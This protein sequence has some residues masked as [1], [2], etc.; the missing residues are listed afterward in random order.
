MRN[1]FEQ[2]LEKL[3]TELAVMG[4]LCEK[5]IALATRILLDNETD[6]KHE[7]TAAEEAIDKKERAIEKHC[8]RL[9]LQQ[10]P[11]AGDLRAISAALKM[12]ADMERIGDQARSIAEVSGS[13]HDYL[14]SNGK[15][16]MPYIR[17]MA[18]AASGIV[19]RSID[20]FVRKDP[21]LA[22]RVMREDAT[23][24]ALF[25][26]IKRELS[27]QISSGTSQ[28]DACIDLLMTAKYLERIGDHAVNIAEWV[29]YSF[30][31][32]HVGDK[33]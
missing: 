15:A 12:I 28:G 24:D 3:H 5:S 8:L 29:E 14:V 31:G 10:Q 30:T 1:H 22:R 16:A 25:E 11:V 27:S 33:H 32:Q 18:D 6:L 17:D 20:S 9:L 13:T 19:T 23:V 21:D 2:Q 7:V 4:A 26:Q